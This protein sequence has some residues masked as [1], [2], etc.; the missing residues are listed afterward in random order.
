MI[1][2]ILFACL[3]LLPV[4]SFA[5]RT[6]TGTVLDESRNP[7]F[8]VMVELRGAKTGAITNSQ[9]QYAL[10]IPDDK[11]V[12]E[13]SFIG[14]ATQ[15]VPVDSRSVVNLQMFE[16]LPEADELINTAW[17]QTVDGDQ[18]GSSYA[19]ISAA[20]VIGS[21]EANL[22][23]GMAAKAPAL[24]I[25]R[26][27]GSPDAGANVFLRGPATLT[28]NS[29]VL[30]LV[31]GIPLLNSTLYD[32]ANG[33]RL[34]GIAQQSRLNDLNPQDI[35]AIHVLTGPSA[36]ALWG[37]R[38][39][40]G[41]IAI[42]TQTGKAGKPGISFRTSLS[43]DEINTHHP[44][45]QTFGQGR[46]GTFEANSPYS[47]GDKL[48]DRTGGSDLT[49][50]G[51]AFF[52]AENGS[53]YYPIDQKNAQTLYTDSNFDQIYQNGHTWKNDLSIKGG[54]EES[55]FYFG[56]GHL[57]QQ[58]IIRNN[59][60]QRIHLRLN[61]D[62]KFNNWLSMA[63]RTSF[64][65]SDANRIQQGANS[66]GLSLGL[67]YTPPDFDIS[68]H[69]GSYVSAAGEEFTGRHRSFRNALGGPDTDPI[70]ANPLWA[71]NQQQNT[72]TVNR[73]QVGTELN[74]DPTSWLRFTVRGGMDAYQDRRIYFFPVGSPGLDRVK[75][76]FNE[77]LISESQFNFDAYASGRFRLGN[78]V[79]LDALLGW[80][81]NDRNRRIN[82]SEIRAFQANV[83]LQTTDLNTS[84]ANSSVTHLKRFISSNRLYAHT[85]LSVLSRLYLTLSATQEA[86]STFEGTAFYPAADLAWQFVRPSEGF[87]ISFGKARIS[88]GKSGI[89][90][91]AHRFE[92]LAQGSFT[93][94][95]FNDG[96]SLSQFGGGF[97]ID[98]APGN[99]N[100]VPETRTALEVGAD[101]RFFNNKLG[102]SATYYRNE[103]KDMLVE[104]AR[105]PS[106]GFLSEYINAGV[107]ENKGFE[108]QLDYTVLEI[109][110]LYV[111]PYA[112]FHTNQNTVTSLNGMESV[113]LTPGAEISSRAVVGY[114][115]GTF[116]ATRAMRSSTGEYE[117][118]ENGFPQLDPDPG[119]IGDPNPD[120]RGGIG[121]R[122]GIS[123]LHLHFLFEHSQGGQY[124]EY[125][126]FLMQHAG[127]HASVGN[128][129]TLTETLSNVNG[130]LIPT[131]TAVRGNIA[132]FGGGNVLLDENWYRGIGAGAGTESIQEFSLTD[133][134][135]T[136]LR[137]LSVS[138][139]FDG[140][141]LKR[142]RLA[143]I[144]LRATG[145]N[146][147]LWTKVEGIDP[148]VNQYGVGNSFGL[149]Y[150]TQ[151][152]TRSYLL[153]LTVTY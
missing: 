137:E 33:G 92:T 57:D 59:H 48:A 136:R 69:T 93:Y 6:V 81:F 32:G 24:R 95:S 87:L 127:T 114:P 84:D 67:L 4:Y 128:E 23:N 56:L 71:V 124:A 117:L 44:L 53:N 38:A 42:T 98:D 77:S 62:T 145:R 49:N 120:W 129:I 100:L 39:A 107:M 74:I 105:P 11:A 36:V 134:T 88:W 22:L 12:L 61:N 131:G 46:N 64:T 135:W 63:T 146:L 91:Q 106:S 102:F 73:Y 121:L 153:S 96:L 3:I 15:A 110:G 2:R 54:S 1:V 112:N 7:F 20:E 82:Y 115:L 125:S 60:Y 78:A 50:T 51:G 68:N 148:E 10:M 70:I 130:T 83:D 113:D 104:V 86:S 119:V 103:I 150:F 109:G 14:Y 52:Q 122:A 21:G 123:N 55:R 26:T 28:G 19:S 29:E 111:T 41:I 43:L 147:F 141:W 18:M 37:T 66:A 13:F 17:G 27:S 97:R 45:Q 58:G 152:A 144:D 89:Q 80:N 90:P 151:P 30:I 126:R 85:T 139:T 94:S 149:D 5:Q 99:P 65:H 143:T 142:W 47:W 34:S 31:D 40:H 8:G 75:G 108:W 132:D 25:T 72:S 133:A 116:W 118:D 76:I 138:Y 16:E 35:H 9:G 79:G 140:D 101:L